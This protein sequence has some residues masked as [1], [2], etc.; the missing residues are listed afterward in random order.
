MTPR[1]GGGQT[2]RGHAM[3]A[4]MKPPL[5]PPFRVGA[6]SVF[7]DRHELAGPKGAVRLEPMGV[8]LLCLLAENAGRTVSRDEIVER[9][10]A[11]RIVTDDAIGRQVKK[12]REAFGDAARRPTVI[13]TVTKLG[14]RL[15]PAV[16]TLEA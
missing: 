10:W 16:S 12:L 3:T 14:V 6:W 13:Q 7:P 11:G 9:L 1:G 5:P 4:P 2:R 8:R 15:L